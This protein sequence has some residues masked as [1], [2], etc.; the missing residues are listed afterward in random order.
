MSTI[1]NRS[2]K[3]NGPNNVCSTRLTR[4]DA[5][6]TKLKNEWP[7]SVFL[8]NN[9]QEIMSHGKR[10]YLSGAAMLSS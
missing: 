9:A 4:Q 7:I 5:K 8:F 3:N 2:H 1:N 6:E 10:N